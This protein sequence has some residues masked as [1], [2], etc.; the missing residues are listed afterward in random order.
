MKRRDFH[1]ALLASLPV[2]A[3]SARSARGSTPSSSEHADN[4]ATSAAPRSSQARACVLGLG[5]NGCCA[6]EILRR[7]WK[8]GELS[9]AYDLQWL[10]ADSSTVNYEETIIATHGAI[11]AAIRRPMADRSW[12]ALDLSD[13]DLLIMLGNLGERGVRDNILEIL[14]EAGRLDKSTLIGVIQ[15]WDV[16]DGIVQPRDSLRPCMYLLRTAAEK[17]FV[18]QE[19]IAREAMLHIS[20]IPSGAALTAVDTAALSS[21]EHAL[22]DGLVDVAIT[23]L[24]PLPSSIRRL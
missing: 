16:K 22:H 6:E 5:S 2:L 7:R 13:V 21:W 12:M 9:S 24:E 18:I 8:L 4:T 20:S 23:A 11:P 10:V 3:I 1:R 19:S 17:I 15:P 14:Y